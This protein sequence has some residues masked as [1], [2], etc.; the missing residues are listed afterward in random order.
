MKASSIAGR[1]WKRW[2]CPDV[3]WIAKEVLETMTGGTT[4]RFGGAISQTSELV[5]FTPAR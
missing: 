2:Y 1:V 5:N 4:G 3:K